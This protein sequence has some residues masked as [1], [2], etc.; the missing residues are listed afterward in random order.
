MRKSSSRFGVWTSFL[1]MIFSI[2]GGISVHAEKEVKQHWEVGTMTTMTFVPS[3]KWLEDVVR[4]DEVRG[5]LLGNRWR[6][7]VYLITG[8]M[9]ASS[10][11]SFRA[12]LEEK[13]LHINVG[14][15]AT[16]WTGV[17]VSVGPEGKWKRKEVAKTQSETEEK[18][19][20]AFRV[21]EIR[22]KRKG[23]V[24]NHRLY[25]KGALFNAEKRRDEVG[26]DEEDVEVEGLGEE[27]EGA[28]FGLE[29]KGVRQ[30]LGDEEGEEECVCVMPE[31]Q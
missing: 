7:K 19:V 22:V 5:Y 29:M 25:D 17:P 6:E 15:D 16:A 8:V 23:G 28:E 26:R 2:G 3:E 4:S 1:Q 20:F 24:K 31:E 18:F 14:V 27:A 11:Q 9:I 10:S 21:R 12:T 13:G 30:A